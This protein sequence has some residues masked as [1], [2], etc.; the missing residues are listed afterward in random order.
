[1]ASLQIISKDEDS[2]ALPKRLRPTPVAAPLAGTICAA[3]TDFVYKV[4]IRARMED[5]PL[6]RSRPPGGYARMSW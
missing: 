2:A 3:M 1:M 4:S 6:C 5:R